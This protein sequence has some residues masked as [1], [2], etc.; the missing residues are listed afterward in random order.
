MLYGI[1][2][3]LP[4]FHHF[5]QKVLSVATSIYN[6]TPSKDYSPSQTLASQYHFRILHCSSF[7]GPRDVPY[8]YELFLSQEK[9][10][11]AV[12]LATTLHTTFDLHNLTW[13]CNTILL[14][15][16]GLNQNKNWQIK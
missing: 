16:N 3:L 13:M 6:F 5:Q 4:V 2:Q 1:S 14:R 9:F 7:S 11:K 10:K 15:N 8:L 12:G